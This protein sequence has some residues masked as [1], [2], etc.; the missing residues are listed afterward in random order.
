MIQYTKEF[1]EQAVLLSDEIGVKKA[2]EQLGVFYNT[3]SDWRKRRNSMRKTKP[4]ENTEPLREREK[5]LIKEI[6][7]LRDAN[8]YSV[9]KLCKVLAV[10]E[11]GYYKW[12]RNRTR[13]NAWQVLLK[14]IYEILDEHPDNYNYGID[15]ILLALNQR[16]EYPSRSTVI[17]A[18]RKGN[19]LH[20]IHRSPD[21]LTKKDKKAN[22]PEKKNFISCRQQK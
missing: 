20:D 16:G 7:E 17:R 11:T 4:A 5:Q 21:G 6:A 22:Q 8:E 9:K 2:A 1:R 12:K 3:L 18:M 19:L 13:K 15:R 14:K 10:S